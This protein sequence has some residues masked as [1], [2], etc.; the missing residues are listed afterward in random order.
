MFVGVADEAL[1]LVDGKVAEGPRKSVIFGVGTT[2][3]ERLET[4]VH[5]DGSELD[6]ITEAGR[7]CSG[8]GVSR[9]DCLK[10]KGAVKSGGTAAVVTHTG[11]ECRVHGGR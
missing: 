8:E 5:V 6:H 7:G 10:G 9:I 1:A 4:V 2:V 3:D 11:A